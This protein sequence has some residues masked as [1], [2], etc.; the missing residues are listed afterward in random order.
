MVNHV[1]ILYIKNI[2]GIKKLLTSGTNEN[3]QSF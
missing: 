3:E 2:E 1:F